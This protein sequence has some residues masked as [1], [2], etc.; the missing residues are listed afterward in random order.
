[1]PQSRHVQSHLWQPGWR[2]DVWARL[3]EPWD[4]IVVGGGIAGA[5]ILREAVRAGLSAVL[6]EMNDFASG[7][8]SRS[9][10]LV[11]GG[12]RYLRQLQ[13]G[14]TLDSVRERDRLLHEGPGLVEPLNFLYPTFEDDKLPPWM[15]QFGLTLYDLIGRHRTEHERYDP[16]DLQLMVPGLAIGGLTGGFRYGDA[17]TDDARLV[18]RVI[19][20]AVQA[21]GTAL[22]YA[23]VTGLIRDAAGQVAGVSAHDGVSGRTTDVRARAVVNA[24]GAWAD[25]LRAGVGGESRLRPLRGSHLVFDA[26]RFPVYQAITFLHPEDGRPVFVVPWEGV[27]FF[28]TTDLDH[29]APLD[30]EPHISPAEFEYLL[31]ALQARFP[32][33]DLTADDV[34]STFAGVRPVIGHGG[35]EP[36]RESR[37]H[38]VWDEHGLLTV[39]GGKLTTF[40][41]IA[42]DA[43]DALRGRLPGL[44]E[45]DEGARILDPAP[46]RLARTHELSAQAQARLLGRYGAEAQEL[47]EAAGPGELARIAGTVYLWAEA[48]WAAQAEGVVHLDDVML[49]RLRLGVVAPEGGISLLPQLRPILQPELDW[50]DCRWSREV[51]AYIELWHR[52]YAG[53]HEI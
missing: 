50:D 29:T 30:E 52:V 20:E 34:L 44:P 18:L 1:M 22:N 21:G 2:D 53:P 32:T 4:L 38:V 19:R 51:E 16:H 39:T 12:L 48:R 17:K 49:R 47:V 26:D 46:A 3:R 35:V 40:R 7:T 23:R 8:S 15:L 11:H 28:G 14:T 33:L 6:L 25:E 37:D 45:S 43:L 24:T 13:L 5:G 41:L 31:A 27:T 36:S 42:R 10:K 9:S